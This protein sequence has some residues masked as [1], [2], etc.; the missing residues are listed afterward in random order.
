M[1]Y[2]QKKRR[3]FTPTGAAEVRLDQ[4]VAAM[5]ESGLYPNEAAAVYAIVIRGLDA[6]DQDDA[7]KQ[8][9]PARGG[10]K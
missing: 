3:A 10:R 7:A 5:V 1:T 6:L 8:S 9:T 4:R 2:Q